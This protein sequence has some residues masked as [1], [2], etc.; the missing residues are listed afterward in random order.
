MGASDTSP[1]FMWRTLKENPLKGYAFGMTRG[2]IF[3]PSNSMILIP[4]RRFTLETPIFRAFEK[5][6]IGFSHFFNA[7]L[8]L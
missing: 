7:P 2:T 1:L 5:N 3:H 8:F 4:N 6:K